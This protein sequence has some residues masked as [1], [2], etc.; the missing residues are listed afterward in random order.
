MEGVRGHIVLASDR[1]RDFFDSVLRPA[2][3]RGGRM[4]RLVWIDCQVEPQG[5]GELVVGRIES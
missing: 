1:Y 2:P 4:A 3:G 5:V